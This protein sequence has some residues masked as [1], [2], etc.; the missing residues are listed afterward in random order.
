MLTLLHHRPVILNQ[1]LAKII[2][3]E[4]ELKQAVQIFRY[5]LFG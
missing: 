5:I 3:H 2:Y 1:V 4:L